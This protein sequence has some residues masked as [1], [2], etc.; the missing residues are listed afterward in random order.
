MNP[1]FKIRRMHSAIRTTAAVFGALALTVAACTPPSTP[2]SPPTSSSAAPTL[3]TSP[4]S[5]KPAAQ[6]AVA[7]PLLASVVAAP[8]PVPATDG[9]D[10]LAY[11]LQLT[12]ALSQ[13]VTITS[14][15][16]LAGDKTLLTLSGDQ[17][18]YWTRILGS[19]QQ[20]TTKV[21]PGLSALVWLDVAVE[22][23]ADGSAP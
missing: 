4:Q 3:S 11:E 2:T 5:P 23:R 20:P 6:P 21:G 15:A 16:V 13:E 1:H 18:A 19:F 17:L 10:H 9:K 12:N 7:P 22:R 8:V 14:L